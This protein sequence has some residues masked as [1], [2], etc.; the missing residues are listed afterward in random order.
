LAN[1]F[2]EFS[3]AAFVADVI[4]RTDVSVYVYER[5]QDFVYELRM[6]AGGQATMIEIRREELFNAIDQR[7]V[8]FRAARDCA[9][10]LRGRLDAAEDGLW[11]QRIVRPEELTARPTKPKEAASEDVPD[12]YIDLED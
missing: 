12:R 2:D 4:R 9:I 3:I 10:A 7:D 1:P 6:H 11:R 5:P 8:I